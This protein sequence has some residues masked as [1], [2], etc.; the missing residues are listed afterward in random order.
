MANAL[1]YSTNV[2]LKFQI[3]ERYCKGIHHVWCS[4]NCDSKTLSVYSA[5]ALVGPSSNPAD[6]YREL[7]RD[8]DGKD[9][10]SAK[11][12]AQKATL[13]GLAVTW[14]AAG[15]ISALEKDEILYLVDTVDFSYWRPLLYVIPRTATIEARLQPVDIA[16]RA[17]FGNEFIIEDLK[18]DEF[19]IVEL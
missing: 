12:G 5:G 4:E 2:F 14:E 18:R 17:G 1:L 13:A 8:V 9:K 3:Q 10:H 7:K 6:I 16:K 19:D 15:E 11:I